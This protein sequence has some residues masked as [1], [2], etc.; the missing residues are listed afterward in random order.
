MSTR[1]SMGS[2]RIHPAGP[3]HDRMNPV[4]TNTPRT[5]RR[6][7]TLPAL[8]FGVPLAVG[9]L[10]L[11]APGYGPLAHLEISRYFQHH[12]ERVEV[13]LFCCALSALA[14]K[15]WR[16]LGEGQIDGRKLLPAWDGKP[17]PVSEAGTLLGSVSRL[18][19]R[20]RDSLLGKRVAAALD[21]IRQRG[22]ADGFDDHLRAMTDN[23]SVS[24]ETSYA[25]VRF[26]TWAMPILGF[27]GTVLGITASIA[28]IT[29]EKLEHDLSSVTDGLALA[30]D[31]TALALS[32]TMVTMFFSFL[33]ERAEQ[34]TL[35][36]IDHYVDQEL[37]HRFERVEADA[38]PMLEAMRLNTETLLQATKTVVQQQADLWARTLEDGDRR[39][40]KV[41]EGRQEKIAAAL[42]AALETTLDAHTERLQATER[43]SMERS[44]TILKQ[45]D[46]LAQ[47]LRD[48]QAVVARTTDGVVEQT[49]V[50]AQLQSGGNQLVELQNSLDRNLAALAGCGSFDQALQSLTAAI[51]LLTA[52]A[53]EVTLA[54]K[55]G[56]MAKRP[57]AAA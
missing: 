55:A 49:R 39:R 28:G 25:L 27:L 35:D 15:F 19:R 20:L 46:H 16:H 51:H 57:G 45:M 41:E 18:P 32:M 5:G 30:F 22:S 13:L 4:T 44:A 9:I 48:Q 1:T 17:V 33:V 23:D 40:A 11:F 42:E 26:L 36:A 7:T 50:L 31:A 56:A 2:D 29:P 6:G 21:F 53:T 37:A 38:S 54:G 24:L 10:A 3:A 14:A 52:R 43:Q 47:A 8:L 12:V 34:S